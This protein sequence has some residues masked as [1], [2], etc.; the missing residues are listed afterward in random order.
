[1]SVVAEA[2]GLNPFRSFVRERKE[3]DENGDWDKDE[4]CFVPTP[5]VSEDG[6]YHGKSLARWG[7][8]AIRVWRDA[9]DSIDSWCA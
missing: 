4:K 3:S 2:L 5:L 1:M 6:C 9:A 7:R 8:I